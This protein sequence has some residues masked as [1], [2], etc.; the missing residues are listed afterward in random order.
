MGRKKKQQ[1]FSALWTYWKKSSYTRAI[2][3]RARNGHKLNS[4][5]RFW[6]L[7]TTVEPKLRRNR[8]SFDWEAW[9]NTSNSAWRSLSATMHFS[10]HR[11]S[12]F[13]LAT[14][15]SVLFLRR[16]ILG[17]KRALTKIRK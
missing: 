17:F 4:T 16:E 12:N 1:T 15:G 11:T 5:E 3:G 7:F 8:N 14:K 2:N 6:T 9:T 13:A 10:T